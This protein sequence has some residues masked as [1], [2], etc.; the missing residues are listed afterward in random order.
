MLFMDGAVLKYKTKAGVN[1]KLE[2]WR[3]ALECKGLW[4]SRT[5][6]EYIQCSFSKIRKK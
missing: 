5:K 4:L 3:T 6:M 2:L 1:Y